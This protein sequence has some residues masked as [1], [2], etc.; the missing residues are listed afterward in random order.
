MAKKLKPLVI[1]GAGGLGREVAWLVADINRQ[2]REWDFVGFVDDGVQGTSPEGYPVLGTLDYFLKLPSH[3]WAVVAIADSEARKAITQRLH[4]HGINIATLIHPSVSMSDFVQ[5]EAG[6]IICSGAVITTNV[7]L[8]KATIVNPKCFIG[9]DTVLGDFV[10][11]M[12]ATNLAG[13]VKVGEGCYFGLNSC[14]INRTKIGKWSIIGAGATV[15]NDIPDYSV[16]VGVP[17]RV[18]KQ[19]DM[20]AKEVY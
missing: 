4:S 17:A 16:A 11:L 3:P 9:H 8:G 10:S 20:E 5:I 2:G 6:S 14:V 1:I 15:I 19:R 13:E 12:P 7:I 18:I